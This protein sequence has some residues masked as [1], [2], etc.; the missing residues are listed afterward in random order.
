MG[1]NMHKKKQIVLRT[2]HEARF[3]EYYIIKT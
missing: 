1:I 2:R 3:V